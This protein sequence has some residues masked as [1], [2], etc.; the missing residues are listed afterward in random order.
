MTL[1][2][3]KFEHSILTREY[4]KAI[5]SLEARAIESSEIQVG[6]LLRTFK[7]YVLVDKVCISTYYEEGYDTK[8]S[9]FYEG[10][11]VPSDNV[12]EIT[13]F[14]ISEQKLGTINNNRIK[15]NSKDK[16]IV[17]HKK[18]VLPTQ[19]RSTYYEKTT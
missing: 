9:Y 1:E 5:K 18:Q 17:L 12:E 19:N 6:D 16:D 7:L 3:F 14:L 8:C 11:V 4:Q 10:F 2:Q 15:F 13:D